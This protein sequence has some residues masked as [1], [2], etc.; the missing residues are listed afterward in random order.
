ML[1][2]YNREKLNLKTKIKNPRK[3]K[4]SRGLKK[5]YCTYGDNTPP[6]VMVKVVVPEVPIVTGVAAKA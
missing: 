4:G 5:N 3:P 6:V 2:H 1:L